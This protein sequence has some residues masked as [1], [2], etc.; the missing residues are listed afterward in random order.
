MRY[1]YIRPGIGDSGDRLVCYICASFPSCPLS[2]IN[3]VYEI[4]S[5][6]PRSN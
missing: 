4:N 1:S 2:Y 3:L 5:G 6:I